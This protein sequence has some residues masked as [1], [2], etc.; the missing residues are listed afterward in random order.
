MII[1]L[2]FDSFHYFIRKDSLF[3][4]FLIKQSKLSNI[5]KISRY[6]NNIKPNVKKKTIILNNFFLLV[7]V[8]FTPAAYIIIWMYFLN[9]Y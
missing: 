8:T 3:Y 1:I 5:N 6:G 7:F 4:S 2:T 9:L